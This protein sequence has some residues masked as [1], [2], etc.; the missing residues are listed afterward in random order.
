MLFGCGGVGLNQK[1][2]LFISPTALITATKD[3]Q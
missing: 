2:I 3:L 1:G